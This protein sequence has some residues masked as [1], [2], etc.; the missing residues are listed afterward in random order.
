MKLLRRLGCL[1]GKHERWR[2][3]VWRDGSFY[4]GICMHCRVPM[5]QDSRRRWH[6]DRVR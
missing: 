2:E 6:V 4:K 5:V 1:V 3:R